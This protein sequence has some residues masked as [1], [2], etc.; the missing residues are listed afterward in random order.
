MAV[1]AALEGTV[2]LGSQVA[3]TVGGGK[4]GVFGH[5]IG[6]TTAGQLIVGGAVSLTR[7]LLL[8]VIE[9]PLLV[10][11]RLKMRFELQRLPT[12]TVTLGLVVEPEIVP[13]PLIVQEK[14][15]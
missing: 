6:E 2:G 14:A 3:L 1:V 10:T 11:V 5:W 8:Q 15:Y 9:Q 4:T 7:K 13:L 12:L